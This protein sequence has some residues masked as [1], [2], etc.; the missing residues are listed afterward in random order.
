MATNDAAFL[1]NSY[2]KIKYKISTT[3]TIIASKNV[4]IYATYQFE[5]ISQILLPSVYN[6]HTLLLGL[7]FTF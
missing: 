5:K 7:K 1:Y 2:D 3:G 4:N 6:L